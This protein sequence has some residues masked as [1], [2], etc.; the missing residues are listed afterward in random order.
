MVGSRSI[1]WRCSFIDV[2]IPVLL[3]EHLRLSEV[4]ILLSGPL[5]V[6]LLVP[7]HHLLVHEGLFHHHH[8][9]S[10]VLREVLWAVGVSSVVRVVDILPLAIA[11]AVFA[12]D[13][14]IFARSRCTRP[15]SGCAGSVCQCSGSVA[16]C[17]R[18]VGGCTGSERA[19]P[20]WEAGRHQF[21]SPLDDWPPSALYL[22]PPPI[23]WSA[24]RRLWI[25]MLLKK[26]K[27]SAYQQIRMKKS[28]AHVSFLT[29]APLC[30]MSCSKTNKFH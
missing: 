3:C 26:R 15:L 30:G 6:L 28:D 23:A 24:S 12:V 27:S 20:L 7:V 22:T 4:G 25:G 10:S 2:F 13:I 5:D 11:P 19:A 8:A 29:P 9:K 18:S 1:F 17:A 21:H 14:L 16:E